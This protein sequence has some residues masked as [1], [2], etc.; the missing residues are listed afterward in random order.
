MSN[1]PFYYQDPFPL[2]KDDTEYR[3]LSTDF[4]SVAQFEGQD[5][6]K[7]DPAALTLLAQQA[8]HDAS[9]ML[10][11][12]HQQQ[13][14][15]IL[16]DPEASENDKYVALQFLRNSEI[17]AKGI[18]PTCQDTGTAIIVGKKGQ[19][20]WT[21][22]NDAEA[23]SKGV[24]NTFIED[25]LRYSQNAALDMYQ[26][27]NTGTNLPAQIDLYSTEGK[28]YKFL[29]VTKGGGSANK[30]Y[31]YQETKALLTPGKLKSFLIEKMRSLGT[32]ACPPYHIAFVI[33]GTSAETTLKT[34]KLAST[35]YYDEL[36]TEGNEHGQ[37]FRDVALEQEILE[38]ARDLGLGA[39]F[40]GKYFAHDVRIIRL[41][42]H[43]ASCPVGMGVSCSA[44]RN[45]K[46]KINRMGVW[47]EQLEQNPGKYIPEHLR[48]TG[49]GDAVKIDLNRPMSEILKTLSQYPVSTRL[50]LT[51]TIIVGRDIA[52]AKLK[53]RLDNGEGLP[54]YIKDHP[55]YYAGPAKTPEGYPSGSLGPTTAGRMDSYVDLLQANGGSMIMLAKGN[56]SQQVTDACHKHGGF[57]LGSI[58]GPAAI[59]AQNSIKS[60]TC[61]EYPELGM[62][63]I[64]K[65]EVEDFPA[66]ILVDDKGNDFFQ[67]I[68]SAKCVKCG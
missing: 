33:G 30:T 52:H 60:L 29:F 38:A 16:H 9:F 50:S 58:G 32:A 40:G 4:V 18:L 55:I 63:A 5:I 59:L 25:N 51:G 68:Q 13:V 44:D 31:L 67:V 57:Y 61:V 39:Q 19:N 46:G 47:L 41:P 26:E 43:G 14:A 3:L 62:E 36:P 6:L 34:V 7:I 27:V 54:Q 65:I 1:K 11:P 10:R 64:W 45:I 35:K 42:R 53:E 15:D 23:L 2:S 49:E 22:G 66:F 17:S 12:A 24:Y 21:G 8:F 56:R 20:V 48:E 37:A 28:D